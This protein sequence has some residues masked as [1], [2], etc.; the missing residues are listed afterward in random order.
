MGKTG[1]KNRSR[2]L[3]LLLAAVVLTG[4]IVPALAEIEWPTKIERFERY[5]PVYSGV[6]EPGTAKEDLGLPEYLRA[7]IPLD[8][9]ELDPASFAQAEPEVDMSD[10]YTHYDYYYYGYVAPKD[11]DKL[12][13]NGELAIYAIYYADQENPETVGEVAYR[14][15]GSINGS[16][17]VWFACDEAGNISGVV[18]DIPVTWEDGGYDPETEGEYLFTANITGYTYGEARPFAKITVKNIE[19]ADG[20]HD[21]GDE[22]SPKCTCGA[23]PDKNGVITHTADCPLYAEEIHCTCEVGE[24]TYSD[25][26]AED[27]PY[28][29]KEELLC[30]CDLQTNEKGDGH[31]VS[32][33]CYV[34]KAVDC[35]CGPN[36]EPIDADNFPWAHQ[37]D[38]IHFSPIECMCRE[39]LETVVEDFDDYG[40]KIGEHNE[41]V[42]GEFSH[43]HDPNNMDCPLYGKDTV[44]IQKLDEN[45]L[46][47]QVMGST[48]SVMAKE[49]AERIVASQQAEKPSE[50]NAAQQTEQ[51]FATNKEEQ[52]D[53]QAPARKQNAV[54]FAVQPDLQPEE[55]QAEILYPALGEIEIVAG[56]E[57]SGNGYDFGMELLSLNGGGALD[58]AS[59][60]YMRQN[61]PTSGNLDEAYYYENAN[62]PVI[63]GTWIDYINTIWVNKGI[64][65]FS[66]M[67]DNQTEAYHSW[68]WSGTTASSSSGTVTDS[69]TRIPTK[70]GA[71]WIVYS[72][73]QLRYALSNFASGDTIR[74]RGNI[75]LDG[76]EKDWNAISFSNKSLSITG[77]GNT[78]YNLGLYDYG[79]GKQHLVGAFISGKST[80][81]GGYNFTLSDLSIVSSKNMKETVI[82]DSTSVGGA[83]FGMDK[84]RVNISNIKFEN[85]LDYQLSE[86]THTTQNYSV[87]GALFANF[88]DGIIQ[89]VQ[90]QGLKVYQDTHLNPFGIYFSGPVQ[91]KNSYIID[92]LYASI[93]FHSSGFMSCCSGNA[94]T[95]ENCFVSQEAYGAAIVTGFAGFNIAAANC[96]ATGRLEGYQQLGGFVW[97]GV[98]AG[99]HRTI[100]NCYS[101]VLV[102]LRSKPRVQAGFITNESMSEK[103]ATLEHLSNCYAAGEVG[104]FDTDLV[105]NTTVQG[106]FV[107]LL[108]DDGT[109]DYTHC[110]YDKQTTA[111]REWVTG[112]SKTLS[113]VTGV[114]TTDTQNASGRTIHGLVGQPGSPG[115][116]GFTGF[117]DNTQ[118]VY[119]DQH[120][121]Q[122]DVF[123][124]ATS[125]DWSS[126][127]TANLVRAY[128]AAS[129]A[130]VFL[131]TW[132]EGYDWDENGVRTQEKVSYDRADDGISHKGNSLTY[133]TV[134]EITTDFKTSYSQDHHSNW[135]EMVEGGAQVTCGEI[136]RTDT[137]HIDGQGNGT[138]NHPGMN[139]FEIQATVNGQ[140]G[141]RPLRLIAFMMVEAGENKTVYAG[142]RYN[143][144]ED[145]DLHM[146]DKLTDNLV[147]GLDDDKIW[148]T[149]SRFG[150]PESRQYYNVQTQPTEFSASKNAYLR[151][152]IWLAEQNPDGSYVQ[153]TEN[154]YGYTDGT[155]KLVPGT[156]VKVTGPGTGAGATLDEQKWNGEIP[157][158][159]DTSMERKYIIS[160]YWVL[161]DGRYNEDYKI[162]T[163]EP[164]QYDITVDVLNLEDDTPNSTLIYPAAGCG[165]RGQ[166]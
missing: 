11:V 40:N 114:L 15:Y 70:S 57:Q 24:D 161:D 96:Y 101:T 86:S 74:L 72:G 85:L 134:R 145:V 61:S 137:I 166:R 59:D 60:D 52:Q 82:G 122:L 157:L 76:D 152:E 16:E 28:F 23:Q 41:L 53:G 154:H 119:H 55:E 111:M 89:N 124:N 93:G 62:N 92:A 36:G 121:P 10:G 117:S 99:D 46:S 138:V 136:I 144:R 104:N 107:D 105:N 65:S 73:E 139:W 165:G 94:T 116:Q 129:T 84:Y 12:Y 158:Y 30:T 39:Q 148:A 9:L 115:E 130:T 42:A 33:P 83:L 14:V 140:T 13:E 159:P 87:S 58:T 77:E 79:S 133:D 29:E 108:S 8:E 1:I 127:E 97:N 156:S 143:H 66:W 56:S 22:E 98:N 75:N 48:T 146:I 160:Y 151:T 43:V 20:S 109:P 51:D 118:W 67:P 103:T 50:D 19:A 34:R 91:I 95:V 150:Y 21:H 141:K 18:L 45:S 120:Y 112:T 6:V 78:I 106:G 47:S 69:A 7:V 162:I 131:N 132:S 49:D 2:L 44:T 80:T 31:D 25:E 135:E 102:G 153:D 149:S 63:P 110:Y 155:N 26:H 164:G 38:C 128:S 123:A 35:H 3:S 126:V 64:M 4:L 81:N 27:C 163:I 68:K 147:I 113:G 71:T 125:T 54:L 5:N 100:E 90:T 37:E 17:N 142:E 88:Y 32:C